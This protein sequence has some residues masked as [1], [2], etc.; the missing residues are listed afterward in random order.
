MLPQH[1][2][3]STACD[4]EGE[5]AFPFLRNHQRPVSCQVL[6]TCPCGNSGSFSCESDVT[7]WQK[8]K[9]GTFTS[10]PGGVQAQKLLYFPGSLEMSKCVLQ[11]SKLVV[12]LKLRSAQVR[13]P[14]PVG[15]W[16]IWTPFKLL[17][18]N[19]TGTLRRACFL[20]FVHWWTGSGAH[21]GPL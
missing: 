10:K 4:W 15:S 1:S 21:H 8:V 9:R 7:D 20:F 17:S 2:I 6:L 5:R 13:G 12:E 3:N 19:P 14:K 16:T 11:G 18:A